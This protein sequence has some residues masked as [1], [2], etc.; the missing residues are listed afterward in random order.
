MPNSEFTQV[1]L[2]AYMYVH[3]CMNMSAHLY[4]WLYMCVH[5]AS[6]AGPIP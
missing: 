1:H 4:A 6:L 5:S 3:T 2:H